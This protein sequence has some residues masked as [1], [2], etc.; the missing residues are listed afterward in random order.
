MFENTV[1][2]VNENV[3]VV[4]KIQ[5]IH[6]IMNILNF[7]SINRNHRLFLRTIIM[8]FDIFNKLIYKESKFMDL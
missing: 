6:K 1:K 7:L 2:Q 5:D 4:N 8:S 3:L